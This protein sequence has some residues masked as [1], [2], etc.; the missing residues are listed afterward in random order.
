MEEKGPFACLKG[1]AGFKKANTALAND[2]AL[3]TEVIR[4]QP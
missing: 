1:I 2:P 4:Q 3:N